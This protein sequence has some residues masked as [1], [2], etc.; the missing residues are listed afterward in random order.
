MFADKLKFFQGYVKVRLKGYAPERFLNLCSNHD[1][2]IWNLENHE[3]QYEFCISVKGFKALKPILK[4]TR[5]S[6]VILERVGLPFWLH[7]Y[8]KRK[9][10]FLGI[11]LCAGALYMMS[12]FIWNIEV[13]GNLHRTDSTIIKFLEEN[14][15]Y[16]GISKSK[17]DCE[18]IEELLRSQYA[19]VIWA[20]VKIQGTRLVIDIQENLVSNQT[21][22]VG[23]EGENAPS[24]LVADR[25]AEIYSILTRQGTPF[26]EKG[27]VVIK[28]DVL[29]EGKIPIYNDSAE[30]VNYQYCAADAD[31]LGITSYSYSDRMSMDYE[32]KVFNGEEKRSYQLRFWGKWLRLPFGKNN[33]SHYD[34]VTAEIPLKLGESF[35]LPIVIEK[36]VA[37][38][39]VLEIKTYPKNEAETMMKSKLEQFCKKLEQKG[40]QIIENNVIIVAEGKS[41][42]AKGE[43][44]VIESIGIRQTTTITE[45]RQEGQITDESDGNNN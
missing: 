27:S 40:V 42:I 30:L 37:K 14:H 22:T 25:E 34:K 38:E 45:I 23:N 15:V 20:S 24:N 21:E 6:L 2:L 32:D 11:A 31:I 16:H 13:D 17:L 3:G 9:I 18:A 26:V 10:F 36:E 19:D 43:I 8:R 12:L 1:I 29:V 4:K 7:R 33:F 28:G 35:Y 41:C 39:Y 44:K 5:T